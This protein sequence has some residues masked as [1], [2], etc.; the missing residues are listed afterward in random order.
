MKFFTYSNKGPRLNNQDNFFVDKSISIGTF[1]CVADGVGGNNGGEVA[2]KLA[3]ETF[4]NAINASS[5]SFKDA[6]HLTHN[7]LIEIANSEAK[8]NGMAT[9][10]T[11]IMIKEFKLS[12]VHVGDSRAYILRGNGL[13]QLS[14]DHTEVARL[15]AEGKISLKESY[16]YPR[17]NILTSAL[18]GPQELV[19]DYFQFDLQKNDR[20][21]LLTDGFY[22]VVSKKEFRDISISTNDLEEFGKKL[23]QLVEEK[24]TT[25]NY[26]IVI[27]ELN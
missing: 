11:S 27:V 2:S 13:K 17:K 19:V 21:I 12:G 14:K 6:I 4:Y 23:V 16:D 26:S 22:D 8:L 18:G 20:I 7:K 1:C 5:I 3:I 24:G 25:D 9:T 10:F 15:V